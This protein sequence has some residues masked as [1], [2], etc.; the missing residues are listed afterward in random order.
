M[1]RHYDFI[2]PFCVRAS[3]ATSIGPILRTGERVVGEHE[4]CREIATKSA[5][6]GAVA[7]PPEVPLADEPSQN[8]V[9][10]PRI[11]VDATQRREDWEPADADLSERQMRPED[12]YA[13]RRFSA[14]QVAQAEN[15]GS[16]WT[17]WLGWWALWHRI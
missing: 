2:V 1:A 7:V 8:E 11:S 14:T 6:R 3:A 12:P 9:E 15:G 17:G 10:A 13:Y 4:T 5:E 16:R